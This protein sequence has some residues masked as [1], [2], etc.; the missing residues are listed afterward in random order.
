M[1]IK[2]Y[3]KCWNYYDSPRLSENGRWTQSWISLPR[4]QA[5]T[6][7]SV[8]RRRSDLSA[9]VDIRRHPWTNVQSQGTFVLP[10]RPSHPR[11]RS[12]CSAFRLRRQRQ[13]CHRKWDQEL[14]SPSTL[15]SVGIAESCRILANLMASFS[16]TM[17]LKKSKR[18]KHM[19]KWLNGKRVL[20]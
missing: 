5:G 8:G 18:A 19:W 4:C 14:L 6:P 13:S 15:F 11:Q 10:F 2:Y 9:S 7:S 20:I 16:A 3:I 12:K 1:H 17:N